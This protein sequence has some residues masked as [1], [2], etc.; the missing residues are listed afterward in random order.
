MSVQISTLNKEVEILA[1]LRKQKDRD[2]EV[3]QALRDAFEESIA[4]ETEAV[5]K[6]KEGIEKYQEKVLEAMKGAEVKSWK[7]NSA[8]VTLKQSASSWKIVDEQ[9]LVDDLF[10]K[11]LNEYTKLTYKPEVKTLFDKGELAGVECVPG[12]EFISVLLTKKT[13]ADNTTTN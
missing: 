1:E 10:I 5:R 9:Q 8:T 11:G 7:S 2:E 6:D 4:K 12:K 3:V 13:D